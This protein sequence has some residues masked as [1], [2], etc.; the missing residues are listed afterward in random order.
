ME[1]NRV[2]KP[3]GPRWRTSAAPLRHFLTFQIL[4]QRLYKREKS[5]THWQRG[6]PMSHHFDT[7]LAKEDPSLNVCDLYL[8]RAL[9]TPR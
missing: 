2:E 5:I 6:K 1:E 7:K 4:A 8:F 3:Q 9:T